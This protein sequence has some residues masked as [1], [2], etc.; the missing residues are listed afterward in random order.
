MRPDTDNPAQRIARSNNGGDAQTQRSKL[1]MIWDE[2]QAKNRAAGPWGVL[3]AS[4]G[5]EQ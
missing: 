1:D 2:C 3:I 5:D 4:D